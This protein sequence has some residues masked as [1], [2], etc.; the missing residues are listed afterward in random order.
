MNCRYLIQEDVSPILAYDHPDYK[1]YCSKNGM[2]EVFPSHCP[3]CPYNNNNFDKYG[4]QSWQVKDLED[5]NE[6][7][8]IT[9]QTDEAL[10][11]LVRSLYGTADGYIALANSIKTKAMHIEHFI[12]LR[13]E[14]KD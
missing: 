4:L 13:K 2:K 11:A 1:Y 10:K 8:H 7:Y 14:Y 9:E 6:V 3:N 5:I 12:N